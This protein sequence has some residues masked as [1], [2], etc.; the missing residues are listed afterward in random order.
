MGNENMQLTRPACQ[1]GK[2]NADRKKPT[3]DTTPQCMC[4]NSRRSDCTSRSGLNNSNR[5]PSSTSLLL[6][7]AQADRAVLRRWWSTSNLK[8]TPDSCCSAPDQN[9]RA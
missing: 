4:C 7:L 2:E 5:R 1:E 8:C 6:E 9:R 3:Q